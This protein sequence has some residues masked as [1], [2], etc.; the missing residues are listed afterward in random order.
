MKLTPLSCVDHGPWSMTQSF[1]IGVDSPN[2]S[3]HIITWSEGNTRNNYIIIPFRRTWKKNLQLTKNENLVLWEYT[4][5]L[6]LS[7]PWLSPYFSRALPFI[8]SR[9]FSPLMTCNHFMGTRRISTFCKIGN[10]SQ[11]YLLPIHGWTSI[12]VNSTRNSV[13][14]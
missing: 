7:L 12:T 9:S 11:F 6:I 2:R 14:V 4:Y 13:S 3:N 1:F 10:Q 5:P 8:F